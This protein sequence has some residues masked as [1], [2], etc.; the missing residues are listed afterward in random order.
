M[1]D[2]KEV[3]ATARSFARRKKVQGVG[4][5]DSDYFISQESPSGKKT[6]CPYYSR[7]ESMIRRC[8]NP[9]TSKERLVYL[10]CTMS[11]EWLLF[12]NFKNWMV[13][14]DW[15]GKHI[16]KDIKIFGNKV[17]SEE[18]CLFVT[19]EVN[20]ILVSRGRGRGKYKLGVCF[21]KVMGKYQAHC[22]ANNKLVHLGFYDDETEAHNVYVKFKKELII[23]LAS[24]QSDSQVRKGLIYHASKLHEIV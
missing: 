21:S 7:W 3:K 1:N 6:R 18:A 11:K 16:D 24:K 10:G 23:N 19:R 22:K 5:N 14:Q 4:V 15:Q 12:S 2:F 9:S 20:N 17:Y 13:K 8:Y